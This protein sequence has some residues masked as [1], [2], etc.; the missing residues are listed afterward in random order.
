MHRLL[1]STLL[2][3]LSALPVA[4]C[5]PA[6]TG[7]AATQAGT[8]DRESSAMSAPQPP[9][10]ALHTIAVNPPPPH[11]YDGSWRI[12][13]A[14]DP[15]AQALMTVSVRS[16]PD[17]AGDEGDFVLFQPFCDAAAG[18]TISG[19]SD[20]E[21]IGMAGDFSA[22]RETGAGLALEFHPGADGSPHLLLLEP[23][24]GRLVGEY[25]APA[26]DVRL[27]VIGERPP[28]AAR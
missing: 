6:G 25:L 5:T 26:N 1:T 22:V 27:R 12:R 20:C 8:G 14:D 7:D 2:A 3:C 24:G 23:D 18:V 17:A 16:R 9:S 21:F 4:A 13:A 11:A 10:P 19:M 28:P 15:H